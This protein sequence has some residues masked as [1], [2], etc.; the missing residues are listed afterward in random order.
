MV[1]II[2]TNR[3]IDIQLPGSVNETG[4][5]QSMGISMKTESGY[6]TIN[7]R[8]V[9]HQVFIGESINQCQLTLNK[10]ITSNISD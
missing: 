2:Y 5:F 1:F 8:I 6:K 10:F 7:Y 3:E 9:D 4:K